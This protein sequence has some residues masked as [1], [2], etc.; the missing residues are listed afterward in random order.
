MTNPAGSV[1]R[2]SREASRYEYGIPDYEQHPDVYSRNWVLLEWVGTNKRVLE[3][4]CSTGFFSRYLRERRGCSVVGIEVD[5]T[6]AVQA[7]RFC[8]EVLLRSE[9]RR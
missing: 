7:R 5:V 6:A 2:L 1:Q 8:N 4:G 3:L 9:E